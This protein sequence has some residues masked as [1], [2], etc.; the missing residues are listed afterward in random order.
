MP[1]LYNNPAHPS[2]SDSFTSPMLRE[3][4]CQSRHNVLNSST[5]ALLT[6]VGPNNFPSN[7]TQMVTRDSFCQFPDLLRRSLTRPMFGQFGSM[8]HTDIRSNP[9]HIPP[10]TL[11]HGLLNVSDNPVDHSVFHPTLPKRRRISTDLLD[12]TLCP[13]CEVSDSST[14]SPGAASHNLAEAAV[15]MQSSAPVVPTVHL[16]HSNWRDDVHSPFPNEFHRIPAS[17][18]GCSPAVPPYRGPNS[19]EPRNTHCHRVPPLS[20]LKPRRHQPQ[21]HQLTPRTTVLQE[22]MVPISPSQAFI[23]SSA[24]ESRAVPSTTRGHTDALRRSRSEVNLTETLAVLTGDCL[25]VSHNDHISSTSTTRY[26]SE[27]DHSEDT[28]FS[29]DNSDEATVAAAAAVASAAARAVAA[30]AQAVSAV[31]VHHHQSVDYSPHSNC[32][33]P[34]FT[35]IS[36]PT[37]PVD[38]PST[39]R[40]HLPTSVC[41]YTTQDFNSFAF[42]AHLSSEA[43]VG[44]STVPPCSRDLS[45]TQLDSSTAGV[46]SVGNSHHSS[47]QP[48]STPPAA[49][50]SNS[51][52]SLQ[53]G[54]PGA[55]TLLSQEIGPASTPQHLYTTF[56]HFG[57]TAPSALDAITAPVCLESVPP[58]STLSSA[59]NPPR[60]THLSCVPSPLLTS[61]FPPTQLLPVPSAHDLDSAVLAIP[62]VTTGLYQVATLSQS[63]HAD[64]VTLPSEV[65]AA[66]NAAT[67]NECS[68]SAFQLARGTCAPDVIVS[69]PQ[70]LPLSHFLINPGLSVAHSLNPA[71]IL[72]IQ[73]P[74][75]LASASRF[76]TLSTTR[77][78]QTLFQFLR[79]V[80]Q[81]QDPYSLPYYPS[82]M[83]AT[84]GGSNVSVVVSA[85]SGGATGTRV[86]SAV[87]PPLAPH[88]VV[89]S[90]PPSCTTVSASVTPPDLI[91]RTQNSHLNSI[92]TNLQPTSSTAVA[93]AAVAMAAAAA[94]Q[95]Q[96]TDHVPTN[97][98]SG[99]SA[100][101]SAPTPSIP[102]PILHAHLYYPT[103]MGTVQPPPANY[104]P[105]CYQSHYGDTSETIQNSPI[106]LHTSVSNPFNN[107][108]IASPA[109][110]TH[111]FPFLLAVPSSS[112]HPSML[113][114]L[115]S[116][117]NAQFSLNHNSALGPD[118]T[119]AA[120]AA[121]A[122]VAAAAAAAAA[123]VD[124]LYQLAFQLESGTNRARGL[125]REELDAL[126]IR[127]YRCAANGDSTLPDAPERS[128]CFAA[129]DERCMICLEDYQ[130]KDL[131]R[132]LKC[133]HEFHAACVDKWLKTKRT[134]PLCRADAFDGTQKKDDI[135]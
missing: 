82:A 135:F 91:Y 87:T 15:H 9:I 85:S 59:L 21:A 18:P 86:A 57:G 12:C 92:S 130:P 60:A 61:H 120:T 51:G 27:A 119:S 19:S 37:A 72:P 106:S 20:V 118:R 104:I 8:L 34:P 35:V 70:Q 121:A 71:T 128:E 125:T 2:C 114:D 28:V 45:P 14:Y 126:S 83:T 132:T 78:I 105:S 66:L 131:L 95:Q 115:P 93:L 112:Q 10:T 42:R 75:S 84:A 56:M 24:P 65:A 41:E 90:Q 7:G 17:T 74:P 40:R 89:T 33:G 50:L 127:S 63:A 108:N 1:W 53:H 76:P 26:S 5:S 54:Y 6:S 4:L 44:G 30:A 96:S 101:P 123:S 111:L 134:C 47:N 38:L 113:S 77:D 43:S 98:V 22:P 31:V 46:A 80:N 97:V 124:T 110:L 88:H 3:A 52:S 13:V 29:R 109:Y 94:L 49:G 102:V 99:L 122:A 11:G 129:T 48:V 69:L 58:C 81:R 133:H 116:P 103:S 68:T 23:D 25:S 36:T 79:L 62:T 39:F 55:A 32:Q 16:I 64:L 67:I 100:P 117:I 107:T 73:T